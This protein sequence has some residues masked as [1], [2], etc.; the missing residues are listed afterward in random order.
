MRWGLVLCTCN[1]TLPVDGKAIGRALRPGGVPATFARL[2]RDELTGFM[3]LVARERYDRVL[4]ACCAAQELFAEA[5]AAAGVEGTPLSVVNLREACYWPHGDAAAATRKAIRLLRAAMRLSAQPAEVAE[6]RLR[7]GRRV[8]IATDSPAGLQLARRLAEVAAP[9]LLLEEGSDR[10]DDTPFHP[11]PWKTTWGRIGELRGHLGAFQVVVERTQPIDLDTCIACRRCI[12]V[13]HTAAISEGLRLR[14]ERCDRCG[15]CLRACEKVGAIRIPR[16]AREVVGAD[17]VVVI[18]SGGIA[19]P[20]GGPAPGVAPPGRPTRTGHHVLRDPAPAELDALAWRIASLIGE[21]DKPDHVRYA[22]DTCAGGH[23]NQTGCGV[24]IGACPYEA[25]ARQGLRVAVDPLACEGCGACVA[26]C[27]TSS[28]TFT[29][30]SPGQLYARLEA[31]LAPLAPEGTPERLVV[32]FHCGERGR[33]ALEAAGRRRLPYPATVLPVGGPCLRYFSEAAILGAFRL[34]AAGVA[35]VGCQSCQHGE[36]ELFLGRVA[37]ARAVLDAFGLGAERVHVITSEAG[38]EPGA[39]EALRRFAEA[40]G[41]PPLSWDGRSLGAVDNRA[42]VTAAIAAFIEQTRREPGR[43]PLGT[44]LP[45]AF[46]DVEAQGC[47]L[48]RSCVNVCP[49]HAFR[50]RAEPHSLE[51]RHLACVACGLCARACPEH[52]ITLRQEVYLDRGALEYQPVVRDEPVAWARCGKPYGN[53]RAL[54]AVEARVLDLPALGDTFAGARR[55]LLRLC[56]DCRAVAA[57]LEMQQGWE[58]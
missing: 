18:R 42:V 57:V 44:G 22:P 12:P 20:P 56:P 41:E 13:C 34:G 7:A 54:E 39:I 10:F 26:A 30:P 8:L 27:P 36:R 11:L 52:V 33:E 37:F 32:A 16:E 5:L 46:A 53:R 1:D 17:Q 55:G 19:T 9:I 47:T 24:C 31:L 38:E 3:S 2:P 4:V 23:A 15:D 25:I 21:F 35:L 28:L 49:T 29:E 45:Y 51:H 43:L 50:I 6:R 40:V 14:L 58:P 48:C